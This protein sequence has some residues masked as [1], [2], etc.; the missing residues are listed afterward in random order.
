MGARISIRWNQLVGFYM[1]LT[2]VVDE[3]AVKVRAVISDLLLA[4]VAWL[5]LFVLGFVFHMNGLVIAA[6][7]LSSIIA[8]FIWISADAFLRLI[9]RTAK[10]APFAGE[11]LIQATVEVRKLLKPLVI[12]SLTFS[13]IALRVAIK[14]VEKT[15]FGDLVLWL[16]IALFASLLS[17][18]L[19][20][21]SKWYP[22]VLLSV[23]IWSLVATFV[24]PEHAKVIDRYLTAW[25]DSMFSNANRQATQWDIDSQV[26]FRVVRYDTRCGDKELDQGINAL[27][28]GPTPSNRNS[29][30]ARGFS[31]SV[32]MITV[33][34]ETEPNSGLYDAT[35]Y[36]CPAVLFGKQKTVSELPT[37]PT[38]PREVES[39][40]VMFKAGQTVDSGLKALPGDT[41][42]YWGSE[43]FYVFVGSG[44][45]EKKEPK[46]VVTQQIKTKGTAYIIGGDNPGY[47]KITIIPG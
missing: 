30:N 2:D 8:W 37:P 42:T 9:G 16:T 18:V 31:D 1:S 27:V 45:T 44:R 43:H 28:I 10:V 40:T 29:N 14:G 5:V 23:T 13:F 47:V 32:P 26:T 41:V 35:N 4:M 21:K 15:N 38:P 11:A 7:M 12:V 22:Y 33:R 6:G 24:A 34:F 25:Q 46:T 3:I 36:H 39:E 17:L 20:T 19:E